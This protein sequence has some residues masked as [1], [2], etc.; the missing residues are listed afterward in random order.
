MTQSL[1]KDSEIVQSVVLAEY[2]Q[3]E[4][5]ETK[6]AFLGCYKKQLAELKQQEIQKKLKAELSEKLAQLESLSDKING[7]STQIELELNN[8]KE[9]A[10]ETNKLYQ[11]IQDN[12]KLE[13][14]KSQGYRL[15]PGSIWHVHD[16][17]VPHVVKQEGNLIIKQR[18][19]DLFKQDKEKE[20][21]QRIKNHKRAFLTWLESM[22]NK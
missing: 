18:P 22:R 14:E 11:A 5:L 16:S 20:C 3:L 17:S 8:F 2:D 1:V 6:V 19:I 10:V 13:E 4:T 7:L 9:I 15:S 12:S 21:H